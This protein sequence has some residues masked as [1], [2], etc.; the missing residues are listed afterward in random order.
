MVEETFDRVVFREKFLRGLRAD[1]WDSRNVIHGV[2]AE[3]EHIDHL[4]DADYAPFLFDFFD[5]PDLSSITFPARPIHFHLLG[6][7]LTEVLVR[8]NQKISSKS[9]TRAVKACR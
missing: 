3:S 5:P 9:W 2:A 8:S 7:E 4:I 1:P 6:D